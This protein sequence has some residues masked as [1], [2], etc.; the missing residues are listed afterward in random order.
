MSMP[1]GQRED[2]HKTSIPVIHVNDA[3][4]AISHF[5]YKQGKG[6]VVA[7]HIMLLYVE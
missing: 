3:K 2:F 1:L 4:Y 6:C 7:L 5:S